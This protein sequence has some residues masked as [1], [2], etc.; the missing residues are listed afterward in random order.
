MQLGG[1]VGDAQARLDGFKSRSLR[2]EAPA[3]RDLYASEWRALE[4]AAASE[5]AVLVLGDSD[6]SVEREGVG[7]LAKSVELA[8]ASEVGAWA[9]LAALVGTER[10][11]L[12]TL[13][14]CALQAVLARRKGQP[15]QVQR[16]DDPDDGFSDAFNPQKV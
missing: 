8:G 11:R 15:A 10:E 7:R 16:M 13:A 14:L 12:A 4:V 2:V 1:A 6:A 3:R 9:A 5:V